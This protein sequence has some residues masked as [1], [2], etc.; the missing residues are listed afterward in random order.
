MRKALADPITVALIMLLA[1]VITVVFEKETGNSITN[2][3]YQDDN[4]S[5]CEKRYPKIIIDE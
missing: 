5:N 4:S 3:I 1:S 2:I